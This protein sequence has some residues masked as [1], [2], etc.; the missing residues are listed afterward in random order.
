MSRAGLAHVALHAVLSDAAA[1]VCFS[2]PLHLKH[3][4]SEGSR[5]RCSH[6]GSSRAE[7]FEL[8]VL[9]TLG[10]TRTNRAVCCYPAAADANAAVCLAAGLSYASQSMFAVRQQVKLMHRI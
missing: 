4:C 6:Y 9:I 7:P 5:L 10:Y 8:P 2:Q 1:V 3:A